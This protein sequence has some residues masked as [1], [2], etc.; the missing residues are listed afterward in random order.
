MLGTVKE[1]A[2]R[3]NGD[4]TFE[5]VEPADLFEFLAE[6]LASDFEKEHIRFAVGHEFLL[7]VKD[8]LGIVRVVPLVEFLGS[9]GGHAFRIV[10]FLVR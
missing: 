6:H 5:W 9:L 10:V 3:G 4:A 8:V 2:S 1:V 7:K